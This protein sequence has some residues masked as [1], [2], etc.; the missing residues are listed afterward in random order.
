M[1]IPFLHTDPSKVALLLNRS[2]VV[3]LPVEAFQCLM[4]ALS[5]LDSEVF[6]SLPQLYGE[7]FGELNTRKKLYGHAHHPFVRDWICKSQWAWDW[8]LQFAIA[9]CHE[10]AKRR[11]ERVGKVCEHSVLQK[12]Y[13]LQKHR[14]HF[15]NIEPLVPPLPKLARPYPWASNVFAART[16]EYR[17]YFAETK[18]KPMWQFLYEPDTRRPHWMPPRTPEQEEIVKRHSRK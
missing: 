13:I 12:L 6:C 16:I 1:L 8:T 11:L 9:A 17:K 3:K 14:P 10:Y 4:A 18:N 2:Y 15:D 5:R 7:L